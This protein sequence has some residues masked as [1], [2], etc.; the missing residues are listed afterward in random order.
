MTENG[1]RDA[2]TWTPTQT[3]TAGST[4]CRIC[5]LFRTSW[6]ASVCSQ[7][8]SRFSQVSSYSEDSP[9]STRI[10]S[11]SLKHYFIFFFA[12]AK[13]EAAVELESRT[14]LTEE[15]SASVG[16]TNSWRMERRFSAC[17]S[18]CKRTTLNLVMSPDR[19]SSLFINHHVPPFLVEQTPALC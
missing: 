11:F 19:C 4:V 15:R 3:T 12:K 16:Q 14:H 8:A 13:Q 18:R 17:W 6:R 5:P 9:K 7:N 2:Q 10:K 1:G